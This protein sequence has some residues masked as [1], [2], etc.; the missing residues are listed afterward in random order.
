[1]KSHRYNKSKW[2][3]RSNSILTFFNVN[4]F[5][6]CCMKH[7]ESK[8]S[9]NHIL[10][11]KKKIFVIFV[12]VFCDEN[13]I[14]HETHFEQWTRVDSIYRKSKTKISTR[15]LRIIQSWI[16][17][18]VNLTNIQFAQCSYYRFD[19]YAICLTNS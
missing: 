11:N 9:I 15:K 7:I 2:I 4:L 17:R 6:K 16:W 18:I 5:I 13:T 1:M 10:R 14:S 19:E 8:K 3:Y 12:R